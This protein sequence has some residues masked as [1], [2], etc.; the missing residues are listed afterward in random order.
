MAARSERGLLRDALDALRRTLDQ[1]L[2]QLAQTPEI[3]EVVARSGR[4]TKL[5][6]IAI[7]PNAS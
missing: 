6:T 5:E 4:R 1:Q 2:V 3:R 7:Q